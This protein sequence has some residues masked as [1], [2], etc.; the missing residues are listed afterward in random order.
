[1]SAITKI[2]TGTAIGAGV[3]ALVSYFARLRRTG[4]HLEVIPKANIHSLSWNGLTIRVDAIL[5]NPTGSSF[6]V[7]FP[8]IKVSHKDVVM[9]SS[10]VI[11]KDITIPAY[12]QVMIERIMI[13]MPPLSFFSVAYTV[14]KALNN[15]E[16]VSLLVQIITTINL[17]WSKVPF[18][19]K[20]EITLRK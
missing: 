7:K 15:K 19:Y 13:E 1:M 18:D 6:S 20:S 3:V 4:I 5:K 2:V 8:F 16:P 17:G 11:D 9:G 14:I 12:G 10:Q